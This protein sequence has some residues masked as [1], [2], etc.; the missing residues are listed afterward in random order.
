[1]GLVGRGVFRC[2]MKRKGRG[3]GGLEEEGGGD[4]LSFLHIYRYLIR[5]MHGESLVEGR[6]RQAPHTFSSSLRFFG[7]FL[8]DH[9][10]TSVPPSSF[11]SKKKRREKT[12]QV[13]CLSDHNPS[14]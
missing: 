12:I 10:V 6:G 11:H 14:L 5:W 2:E 1:M 9:S 13:S 7:N 8:I 4:Y 3:L